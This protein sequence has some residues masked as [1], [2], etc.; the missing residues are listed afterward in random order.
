MFPPQLT[1]RIMSS[2]CRTIEG[3]MRSIERY[4]ESKTFDLDADD[5]FLRAISGALGDCYDTMKIIEQD[6]A[7]IMPD[8]PD[9]LARWKRLRLAVSNNVNQIKTDMMVHR[10][11]ARAAGSS[12][13]S[14]A[15]FSLREDNGRW[16]QPTY[17]PKNS[18]LATLP[19]YQE[20]NPASTLPQ[21]SKSSSSWFSRS[22][23]SKPLMTRPSWLSKSPPNMKARRSNID[24]KPYQPHVPSNPTGSTQTTNAKLAILFASICV[25]IVALLA[26]LEMTT[27]PSPKHGDLICKEASY[28]I[29][30]QRRYSNSNNGLLD[31]AAAGSWKE[32]CRLLNMGFGA[33]V[34]NS[35]H[36]TPLH[37]AA[38]RG[39]LKTVI[40]FLEHKNSQWYSDGRVTP[41]HL[42]ARHGHTKTVKQLKTFTARELAVMYNHID[43]ALAFPAKVKDD[44]LDALSCACI[45]GDVKLVEKIW[46]SHQRHSFYAR[47]SQVKE[48]VRWFPV[49]PLHLA[50]ISGSQ[51]TVNFLLEQGF[52]EAKSQS[53]GGKLTDGWPPYSSPVHYAAAV[54]SIELLLALK[55]KGAEMTTL[56]HKSRT[57][58]SYA[59]ESMHE[60][61]VEILI[62][63]SQ[64]KN[65]LRIKSA[66]SQYLGGGHLWPKS[67][68]SNKRIIK[69]LKDIGIADFRNSE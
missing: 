13:D 66:A 11:R 65:F 52:L 49:P 42:A 15:A 45:L 64:P 10:S 67:L 21:K 2:D 39:S 54:G 30:F 9:A 51:A 58:L 63:Q 59:V 35:Q 40:V 26:T 22:R 36:E 37:L 20:N 28:G 8:N 33:E 50:V 32:T 44:I 14:I 3:T 47:H 48:A 16:S 27:R 4:L 6:I 53:S 18:S 60:A 19:P 23:T 57:P 31:A 29:M 56:D 68:I 69:A 1:L 24:G 41:L 34:Q 61:I 62:H 43:T 25:T 5:Y 46:K 12:S 55:Q 7:A 38:R 17:T